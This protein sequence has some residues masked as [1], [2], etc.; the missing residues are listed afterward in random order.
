MR[1]LQRQMNLFRLGE[2]IALCT[3]YTQ[4][5][6]DSSQPL[7][8]TRVWM[9]GCGR[10]RGMGTPLAIALLFKSGTMKSSLHQQW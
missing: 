8:M 6:Q 1:L 4:D 2:T 9:H 10:S 7:A 5:L 3:V